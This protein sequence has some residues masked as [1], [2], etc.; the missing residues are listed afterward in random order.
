[1]IRCL[2]NCIVI[3]LIIIAACWWAYVEYHAV[4]KYFPGLN[5][6]EYLIL[7]DKLRI[8]PDWRDDE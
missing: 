7:H 4:K 3:P 8:T 5:Y 2:V 1:M 6:V